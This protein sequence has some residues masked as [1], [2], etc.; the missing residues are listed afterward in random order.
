MGD[1]I[2]VAIILAF[3]TLSVLSVNWCDRIIGADDDRV[4]S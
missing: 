4:T 2:Y 3:F 1:I